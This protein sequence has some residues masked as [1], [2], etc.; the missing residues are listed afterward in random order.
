MEKQTAD[1][2]RDDIY[3]KSV[4]PSDS[5]IKWYNLQNNTNLERHQWHIDAKKC[6]D[7]SQNDHS[8]KEPEYITEIA[9]LRKEVAS[10][11]KIE[12]C[13]K[14]AKQNG[15]S[16]A[17]ETA[18]EYCKLTGKKWESDQAYYNLYKFR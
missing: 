17:D 5:Y 16:S 9:E 15:Y 8:K 10:L 1:E 4:F 14:W 12:A 7:E 6:R 11:S 18:D 3:D 2:I 13:I